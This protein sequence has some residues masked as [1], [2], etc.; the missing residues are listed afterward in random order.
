[1]GQQVSDTLVKDLDAKTGVLDH[2]VRIFAEN[3]NASWLRLPMHCFYKT[4]PTEILRSVVDRKVA[5]IFPTPYTKK[6]VSVRSFALLSTC[7]TLKAGERGSR[8]HPRLWPHRIEC[9]AC[10]NEQVPRSDRRQL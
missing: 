3:A 10:F 9:S 4:Q 2:L 7:L 1:M 6:I 8:L 5:S